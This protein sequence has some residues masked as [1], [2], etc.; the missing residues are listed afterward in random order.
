MAATRIYAGRVATSSPEPGRLPATL[1]LRR[2]INVVNLS[3]PL[4]LLV[5]VA[6]RARIIRGPYGLLLAR[7]YRASFPAPRAPAVTIGDVV[8]LRLDDERMARRPRLLLHES[9]HSMQYACWLGPFGFLPAYLLASVWSWWHT[10]DFAL[11][12]AFECRAGLADGGY[13]RDHGH[14]AQA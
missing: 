14:S 12:N 2:V 10:G 11:R 8:L 13:L 6:G 5:A 1:R 3:T 9:R 4:G 7:D